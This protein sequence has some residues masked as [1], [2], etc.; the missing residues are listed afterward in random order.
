MIKIDKPT[1]IVNKN[2]A[3]RNIKLMA[4]KASD[5]G[6]VLTPHFKTHQS[7]EIGRW[8]REET[9]ET[10]T[11][12]S[13]SMAEYFAEDSWK[14]I[15]IAFPVN[16]L[17]IHKI[18]NLATIVDLTLLVTDKEQI[19]VLLQEVDVYVNILIEIDTG[20]KRSGLNPAN[21]KLISE[22]IDSLSSTQHHFK[23]FYS[24]FGHTYNAASR[25]EVESIYRE[26][27]N[28]MKDLKHTHAY[29]KP[30]IS[31]GDTPSCSIINDFAEV[32]SIHAGNF[33]FYDLTQAQIGSC[34]EEDIAIA[35]ACPVVSKNA[36]RNEIII[37]GGGVHLSKE[38]L[39]DNE[40]KTSIFGKIVTFSEHGWSRSIP[41]CYVRSISQEH[42]VVKLTAE[43]FHKIKIGDVIG[44]LPVHS[45]MT[46]DVMCGYVDLSGD[47]VDH[48]KAHW[49]V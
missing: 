20:S 22:M 12:S 49:A 33:V 16:I 47:S 4:K 24:H 14:H 31:I 48:L 3:R 23:G 19:K 10:I 36:E 32:K 38:S 7:K 15:T 2:I 35:L 34:K 17:E 11:V 8:F 30:T 43:A 13:V 1:L 45:C 28:I 37:Y 25:V 5:N 39:L 42:G 40:T 18:A 26:S 27:L 9:I 41:G 44:V 46:A 6:L 21:G 29:A